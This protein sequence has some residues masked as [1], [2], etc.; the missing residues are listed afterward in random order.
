VLTQTWRAAAL[1]VALA[2]W[3]AAIHAEQTVGVGPR[4]T[5]VRGTVEAESTSE[6]YTGGLL[7]AHLSPRTA[8]ELSIDWRTVTDQALT[9]RVRNYP[10]QGSLLLYP[11]RAGLSPYLLG[12]VG[13]YSQRVETL[14]ES[15]VTS[16]VTTRTFGYHAGFGGQIRMGRRAALHLD[17]RYTKIRFGGDEDDSTADTSPAGEGGGAGFRIPGVSSLAERLK[18]SHDGSMWTGGLTFYF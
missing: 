17:Y 1:L 13:W 10:I 9:Q 4:F 14:S 16:T 8:V 6:R 5:V 11:V 7:R 18:L 12:G 15:T 3:P 2:S